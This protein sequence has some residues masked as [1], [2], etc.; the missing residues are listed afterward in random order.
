MNYHPNKDEWHCAMMNHEEPICPKCGKGRIICPQGKIERP[1]YFECTNQ[2][3]FHV[4]LDYN[5]CIIE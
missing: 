5:D 3:G 1:H 2:C 4:N